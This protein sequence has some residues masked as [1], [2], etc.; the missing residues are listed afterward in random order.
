MAVTTRAAGSFA[1]VAGKNLMPAGIAPGYLTRGLRFAAVRE[2]PAGW[3]GIVKRAVDV[4]VSLLLLAISMPLMALVALAVKLDSPGP[5]LIRQ[6]RVG[7]GL[8][9]FPLLKFR[10]MVANAEALRARLADLN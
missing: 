7:R 2:A 4:V 9:P 6:E 5:I 10:S 1:P 3:S 8:R